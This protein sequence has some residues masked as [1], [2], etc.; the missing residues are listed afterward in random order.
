MPAASPQPSQQP[1]HAWRRYEFP[2]AGFSVELP[3]P[4]DERASSAP[5]LIGPVD[6][7]TATVQ[8]SATRVLRAAATRYPA[9]LF[10][11]DDVGGLATFAAARD[12]LLR[13]APTRGLSERTVLLGPSPGRE[14]L[15]PPGADGFFGRAQL[16]IVGSTLLQ[17]ELR[18]TQAPPDAAEANAAAE[19]F[20][21]SLALTGPPP[22]VTPGWQ[23]T[24]LGDAFCSVWLPGAPTKSLRQVASDAGPLDRITYTVERPE[25]GLRLAVSATQ[26]PIEL[27]REGDEAVGRE[28]DRA[29][30]AQIAELMGS[31]PTEAAAFYGQAQ[32]RELRMGTPDGGYAIV[33]LHMIGSVLYELVLR[34]S[35]LAPAPAEGRAPVPSGD[36]VARFFHTFAPQ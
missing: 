4:P 21:G 18:D 12:A 2:E 8:L 19:R 5:T 15:V 11:L 28:L 7:L 25:R 13:G 6:T 32:G 3:A 34:S 23:P 24:P 16:F 14:L 9:R 26:I 30:D 31:Q 35:N 27:L 36:E 1:A 29:R 33:R 22:P 10:E 17:L 20:F